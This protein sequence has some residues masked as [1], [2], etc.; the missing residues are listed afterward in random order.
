MT[1]KEIEKE[2]P[3]GIKLI[4]KLSD[5]KRSRNLKNLKKEI[6]EKKI[7]ADA[8]YYL[9]MKDFIEIEESEKEEKTD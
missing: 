8:S 7:E 3:F 1:T 9:A 6:D 4:N 2:K 5:G